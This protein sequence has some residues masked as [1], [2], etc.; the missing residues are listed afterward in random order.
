MKAFIKTKVRL[1]RKDYR[2]LRA[3]MQSEMMKIMIHLLLT[4][5]LACCGH[6]RVKKP[7]RSKKKLFGPLSREIKI[8]GKKGW[9]STI[10]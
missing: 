3:S 6:P 2:D 5:A 1:G 10:L 8:S 4:K 9:K 7:R